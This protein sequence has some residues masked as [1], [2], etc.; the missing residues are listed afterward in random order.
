MPGADWETGPAVNL[1]KGLGNDPSAGTLEQPLGGSKHFTYIEQSDINEALAGGHI[2]E[3]EH[4]N[5]MDVHEQE[6]EA[7]TLHEKWYGEKEAASQTAEKAAYEAAVPEGRRRA[8]LAIKDP[9]AIR[10]QDSPRG[11]RAP[12]FDPDIES[13]SPEERK[14]AKA[15]QTRYLTDTGQNPKTREENAKFFDKDGNARDLQDMLNEAK[16]AMPSRPAEPDLEKASSEELEAHEVAM[17]KHERAHSAWEKKF[18]H[19]LKFEGKIAPKEADLEDTSSPL[20]DF[21]EVKQREL[22]AEKNKADKARELASKA[23]PDELNA[24][25]A[26]R[27]VRGLPD[28]EKNVSLLPRTVEEARGM[29]ATPISRAFNRDVPQSSASDVV[30]RRILNAI[31]GT[32]GAADRALSLALRNAG[33]FVDEQGEPV[34]GEARKE[35]GEPRE[36]TKVPNEQIFGKNPTP[37][38][39]RRRVNQ[40]EARRV[41]NLPE[42]KIAENQARVSESESWLKT[43]AVGSSFTDSAGVSG[44]KYTHMPVDAFKE[45]V[46]KHPDVF[47]EHQNLEGEALNAAHA[48]YKTTLSGHQ[49][50]RKAALRNISNITKTEAEKAEAA[51]LA[52][53]SEAQLRGFEPGEMSKTGKYKFE[54]LEDMSRQAQSLAKSDPEEAERLATQVHKAIHHPIE[55]TGGTVP[56]KT[57]TRDLKLVEGKWI[58]GSTGEPVTEEEVKASELKTAAVVCENANC[59]NLVHEDHGNVCENCGEAGISNPRVTRS[60][61][62]D[63]ERIDAA[64][65]L[66]KERR[67][68]PAEPAFTEPSDAELTTK[69][70]KAAKTETRRAALQQGISEAT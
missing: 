63:Q 7:R 70:D 6:S 10:N 18:K 49:A 2:N 32:E 39:R 37:A 41:A 13:M 31:G 62:G 16:E 3:E 33:D 45:H 28:P 51:R 54:D 50:T 25:A 27:G 42:N 38:M 8:E 26:E 40:R 56:M 52:K 53:P 47:P 9:N 59:F 64:L 65:M 11:S 15:A 34:K 5:L 20:P 36:L 35:F 19:I 17:G 14:R 43:H 12:E 69:A 23:S 66:D 22:K 57:T 44:T 48:A 1:I 29:P 58:K 61:I 68:I 4:K 55:G 60:T 46:K 30:A 21:S 24:E 67:S